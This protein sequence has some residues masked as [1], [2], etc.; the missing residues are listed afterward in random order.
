MMYITKR[1]LSRRTFLRGTGSALALP[2]VDAMIPA[3]TAQGRTPAAPVTRFGFMYVPHGMIM[4]KWIPA[5]EGA[6]FEFTPI[7]KPLERFRSQLTVVGNLNLGPDQGGQH[8]APSGM[9]LNNTPHKRTEAEDV[10]AGT[11]IDQMIAA[12]IGQQTTFPSLELATEDLT[13]LV[14]A[15]DSGFSCTYINT[16][17]WSTPTTPLPMEINPRVVFERM[18]GDPGTRDQ[19]L[20]RISEDRNILDS[21]AKEESRLR[22]DLGAR[23]RVRIS[24]YLDNVREIERRIQTAER[25]AQSSIEIPESP[26]GV[27]NSY[28]EHVGLMF[29]LMTLAYQT[30][31]TRVITFMIARELSFR[32]YPQ[33]NVPDPHHSISHHQNDP[34]KMERH[35]RIN[36]YHVTLFGRF[37]QKLRDTPDGDGSLLDHSL[38]VYGSGMANGNQ[39]TH[40]PLPTLV[41]GGANG[42]HRGNRH[43]VP[44]KNTPMGN[45]LL[46]VLDK[47]GVDADAVGLSTGRV[48]L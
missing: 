40:N 47:A 18:F 34:E 26:A 13:S 36:T 23:D 5:T 48:E 39:H 42:R 29:D 11:T 37:L 20:A 2:L 7:L 31:I 27:P 38:M 32:S 3:L 22:R 30:D 8:S 28:E 12:K 24:E 41:V 44:E 19:R 10:R 46:A 17:C 4:D 1:S 16:L 45:F 21:I 33:V 9:W 35:A 14:G 15:C 25:Q 6:D 43:L